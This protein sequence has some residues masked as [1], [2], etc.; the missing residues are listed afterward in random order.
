MSHYWLLFLLACNQTNVVG[1]IGDTDTDE[2]SDTDTDTDV[3]TATDT[4]APAL[5]DFSQDGPHNVTSFTGETKVEADCTLEWTGYT[6][7]GVDSPVLV[8]LTHGFARGK[9]QMDGWAKIWASWGLDVV[10]PQMCHLSAWDTQHEQNGHDL[11]DLA[12]DLNQ[13]R[14]VIYVGHSAGGLASTLAAEEDMNAIGVLGLDPVDA[15][16]LG[17]TAAPKLS[18]P[19][20]ALMGISGQCNSDQN[21]TKIANLAAQGSALAIVEA[22]HCDFENPT[23]WL[24]EVACDNQA[25]K[26]SAEEIMRTI[27]VL[28]TAWLTSQAGIYPTAS[29]WWDEDDLLDTLIQANRVKAL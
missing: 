5:P 2:Q 22:D 27:Q 28:S 4:A 26:Q 16:N 9:A 7:E 23:D 17:R 11:V 18:V 6:A 13:D 12:E 21:G 8:V 24:C 19:M 25:A 20:G 1:V 29:R 14:P 10:A 3:D 15:D